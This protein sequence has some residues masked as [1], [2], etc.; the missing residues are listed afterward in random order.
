MKMDL[1]SKL[2]LIVQKLN[3]EQNRLKTASEGLCKY[4]S[5]S[6]LNTVLS[7]LR[8]LKRTADKIR[9]SRN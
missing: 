8:E 2:D 3:A 6:N 5:V 9:K 7:V 4:S 1:T